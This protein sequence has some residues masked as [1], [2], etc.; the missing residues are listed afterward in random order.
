M[1]L[2]T[3]TLLSKLGLMDF[4]TIV[5]HYDVNHKYY[6]VIDVGHFMFQFLKFRVEKQM[7]DYT[8]Y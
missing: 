4:G 6:G 1:K 2:K 7:C 8:L 5:S 3:L